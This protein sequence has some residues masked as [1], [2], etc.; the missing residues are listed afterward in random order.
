M[1]VLDF[2]KIDVKQIFLKKINKYFTKPMYFGK[3]FTIM[4]PKMMCAFGI[5]EAY[6]KYGMKLR[7][8]DNDEEH[9]QFFGGWS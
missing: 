7:F 5:E 1:E 8:N 9:K 3:S 4:T 2:H 6:Q